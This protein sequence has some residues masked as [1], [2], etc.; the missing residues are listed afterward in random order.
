MTKP[1]RKRIKATPMYSRICKNCGRVF[2]A[3]D[4]RF[5]FCSARCQVLYDTHREG[6]CIIYDGK[7][8]SIVNTQLL[9][10]EY[11][12]Y[13]HRVQLDVLMYEN[14]FQVALKPNEHI[15]HTCGNP[16]CLNVNHMRLVVG[17]SDD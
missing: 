15:E 9:K 5:D 17:E 12:Y 13:K 14:A 1:K 3:P 2:F 4:E 8:T 11:R 6:D 16:N 10:N 7:L